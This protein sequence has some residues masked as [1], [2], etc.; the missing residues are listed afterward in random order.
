MFLGLNPSTAD[1][2]RN[3]HTISRCIGYARRWGYGGVSVGNLFGF[4]ATQPQVMKRA[5]DPI[6][7][8][9]DRWLLTLAREADLIV[10]I[11]GNHGLFQNRYADVLSLVPDLHCLRTTAKG[12][13][14]HVRGLPNH[15]VP[16]AYSPSQQ[17]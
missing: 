1:A 8:D 12:Q 3:D 2:A 16:V 14:H 4:R 6:G 17:V 10:A 5:P 15:L 7:P 11:W 13:P 9:N